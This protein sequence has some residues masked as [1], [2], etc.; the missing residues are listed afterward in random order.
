MMGLV[1][2]WLQ[3]IAS[4]LVLLAMLAAL[5]VYYL[6]SRSLPDY[7]ATVRVEGIAAPVE[8]VRDNANV[9]HI[10]GQTLSLIHISEPTRPY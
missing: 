3:R 1:F 8:I 4:G 2:Q 9:P 5:L 7:D 10:L 6:A